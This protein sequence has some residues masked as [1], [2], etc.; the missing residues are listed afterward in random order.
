MPNVKMGKLEQV[1]AAVD[2][3]LHGKPLGQ[4]PNG[5]IARESAVKFSALTHAVA[6]QIYR[7]VKPLV[8][9]YYE[10]RLNTLKK[11]A[12]LNEEGEPEM[13]NGIVQFESLEMNKAA[14]AE[15][16]ELEQQDVEIP[17]NMTF[18]M[19]S[20]FVRK[21]RDAQGK[22]YENDEIDGSIIDGLFELLVFP[23]EK[24]PETAQPSS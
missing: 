15:L 21:E 3:M 16:D 5:Q 8:E 20:S 7:L 17:A 24:A 13:V 23:E 14:K 9:T 19:P 11:F 22:V 18:R 12:K 4:M 1:L 2:T 10:A 6:A